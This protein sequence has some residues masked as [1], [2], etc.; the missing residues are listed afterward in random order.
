MGRITSDSSSLRLAVIACAVSLIALALMAFTPAQAQ[1]ADM[2]RMYNPNSGEHFY[3]ADA[4]ERNSLYITGWDYEGIGWVA[5]DAG[6]PVYRLYNPNAGDHHYTPNKGEHDMLVA[7]GWNDEGVGWS[8][9]GGVPLYRQY[10]PNAV[11]GSHNFT[12]NKA[13]NDSL[14][15]VGWREE[16]IG[17]YGKGMGRADAIPADIAEQRR[18]AMNVGAVQQPQEDQPVHPDIVYV[19]KSGSSFHR[20]TCPTIARRDKIPMSYENAL[21]SGRYEPCKVCKP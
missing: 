4:N 17:W 6:D 19:T 12:T 9:G 21:L 8:T 20:E 15:A 10:N 5:P 13:E 2:Y 18:Q 1:A 14:V 7:Q 16:G 11:A 3:T